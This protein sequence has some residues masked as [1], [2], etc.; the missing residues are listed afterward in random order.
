MIVKNTNSPTALCYT[1]KHRRNIPGDCH[2]ACAKVANVS[3]DQHGYNSGWFIYPWN[4]DPIWLKTCDGF[5]NKE[6]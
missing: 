3:A 4:F 5:E 1:C 2:S 6:I